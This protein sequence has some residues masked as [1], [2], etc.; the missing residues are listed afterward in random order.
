ML[1]PTLHVLEDFDSLCDVAAL[2]A[3]VDHAAVRDSIGLPSLLI[4]VL[5]NLE[6]LGDVA[7]LAIRL[8]QDAQSDVGGVDLQ[9]PH[10]Q[11]GG[12]E[13][14]QVLHPAAGVE[15]GIEE[16]LVGL[17][18]LQLHEGFHEADATVDLLRVPARAP[19]RDGLH[20]H[21]GDRVLVRGNALGLHLLEGGPGL[22]HAPAAHDFLKGRGLA[23]TGALRADTSWRA[24]AARGRGEAGQLPVLSL[25][26]HCLGIL[27]HV[28][29]RGRRDGSLC[30]RL[31]V[32]HLDGLRD[33]GHG[34]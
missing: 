8:Y 29:L 22:V 15:Q 20:E 27:L 10:L 11:H 12:L 28:L 24:G 9:L 2:H 13:P 23:P 31:L 32:L 4:H 19:L 18:G 33:G 17:L 3:G 26:S 25:A 21:A 30:L 14:R 7:G 1:L 6:D 16:H 5:P 34:C